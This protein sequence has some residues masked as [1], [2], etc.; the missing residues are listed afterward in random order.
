MSYSMRI[1]LINGL[2][3]QLVHQHCEVSK[4]CEN[5]NMNINL[6]G[7][8]NPIKVRNGGNEAV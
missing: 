6:K 4:Q 7:L 2:L 5:S 1:K 3:T 8:N